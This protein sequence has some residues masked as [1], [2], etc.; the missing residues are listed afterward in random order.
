MVSLVAPNRKT[1]LTDKYPAV[2]SDYGFFAGE[3]AALQ[4]AEGVLP[5]EVNAALFSDYAY[6][7]RMIRMPED[8]MATYQAETV[9]D[10]P[11]GTELIK[12]F[13]YPIDAKKP[14][15][16]RIIVE[17]R[18]LKKEKGKW[19]GLPYIWN[20]TQTEAFLEVAGGSRE[21]K[22]KDE[23][24][25]KQTLTYQV[26]NMVQCKS[27]HSHAAEMVP[28]GIT[29]RQLNR[30]IGKADSNQ[31]TKWQQNALLQGLPAPENI[32]RM[33]SWE[34]PESGTV[35]DRARAYLDSNCG[36]CHNPK[37][38]ANTS[39]MYLDIATSN[40]AQWGVHKA[41]IAAGKGAGGRLFGIVPG[42]PN[43]SILTYRMESTDPGEMMPELGRQLIHKEGLDLVKAWI[44][45][46]E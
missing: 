40:P 39:G 27:C 24:G 30:S 26:P 20:E 43:A 22:W 4:P 45:E 29:A 16:G 8:A 12:T 35:A 42:Q 5:Y 15:K 18:V 1:E 41:P 31:L 6:K 14:G 28:I 25:K 17:T 9:F 36:H 7:S 38:P 44:K 10:L 23:H 21:I 34:N 46:M 32:P 19:I 13:Y 2:L 37:G 11:E 33:A 3:M